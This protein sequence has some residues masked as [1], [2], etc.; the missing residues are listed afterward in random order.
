MKEEKMQAYH[1]KLKQLQK[2]FE[3]EKRQT[4]EWMAKEIAELK[5]SDE[6]VNSLEYKGRILQ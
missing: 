4:E 1:E 3:I 2:E 5:L 6:E